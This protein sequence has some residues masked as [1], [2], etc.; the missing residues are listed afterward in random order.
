MAEQAHSMA[1]PIADAELAELKLAV[2]N[3]E[4]VGV[5]DYIAEKLIARIE[6]DTHSKFTQSSK[7]D[8]LQNALSQSRLHSKSM[9]NIAEEFV[10]R[11]ETIE[12]FRTALKSITICISEEKPTGRGTG[13]PAK[14]GPWIKELERM[15]QASSNI[16]YDALNLKA[17]G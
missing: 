12:R 16:A 1:A 7:I 9:K 14:L 10:K 2:D 6:A 11:D 3:P 15:V 4:F 13:I 5:G 8:Q 17:E